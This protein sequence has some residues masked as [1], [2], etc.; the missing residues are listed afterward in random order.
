MEDEQIDMEGD[1]NSKDWDD[2]IPEDQRRRLEEEERQKELEEIYLLPRMRN[3]A[4][5]VSFNHRADLKPCSPA[6]HLRP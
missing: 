2:I 5:Q 6:F 3:C 1:G 4:K